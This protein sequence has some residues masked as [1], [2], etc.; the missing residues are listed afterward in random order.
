M[1]VGSQKRAKKGEKGGEK[2]RRKG[3]KEGEFLL[4]PETGSGAE[5]ALIKWL[6]WDCLRAASGRQ[7]SACGRS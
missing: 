6:V 5:F 3:Q 7:L 1:L 2:R 4:R